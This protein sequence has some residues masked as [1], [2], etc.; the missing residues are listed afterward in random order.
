MTHIF[1]RFTAADAPVYFPGAAFLT[2]AA[3]LAV[4]LLVFLRLQKR[5]A[6]K[7]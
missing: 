6:S 1:A 3:L 4:A 2:A 7:T 5:I